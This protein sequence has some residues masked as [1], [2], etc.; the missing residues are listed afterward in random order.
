MDESTNSCATLYSPSMTNADMTDADRTAEPDGAALLRELDRMRAAL[1][2]R[3]AGRGFSGQKPG[4]R[5]LVVSCFAPGF[6]MEHWRSL[7]R[8]RTEGG[9][10]NELAQWFAVELD[11][12]RHPQLAAACSGDGAV[13]LR[14]AICPDTGAL[15]P[16][17]FL[18]NLASELEKTRRSRNDLSLVVLEMVEDKTPEPNRPVRRRSE[19]GLSQIFAG[20]ASAAGLLDEAPAPGKPGAASVSTAAPETGGFLPGEKLPLLAATLK[21]HARGCD[22]PARLAQDRMGLLMPGAGALRARAFAERLISAFDEALRRHSGGR[23]VRVALRAGI[24]CF[25]PEEGADAEALVRQAA[26]ALTLAQPG[27]T[28]TFRKAGGVTA[29]RRTQVQACEKQFLFFGAAEPSK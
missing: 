25:D 15:L 12:A 27:G 8:E 6:S 1:A 19:P 5:L 2:S 21:A 7:V 14:Q 13:P 29:E 22:V 16:D 18:K 10:E 20:T 11:P 24:A 9:N 26:T 17:F 23:I 4:E 28:R 3:L